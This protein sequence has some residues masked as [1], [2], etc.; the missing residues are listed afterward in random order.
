MKRV[1]NAEE[2]R[3]V[4]WAAGR[5]CRYRRRLA[6]KLY[7]CLRANTVQSQ[8]S[9][10]A[11]GDEFLSVLPPGR[12]CLIELRRSSGSYRPKNSHECRREPFDA[13]RDP[14]VTDR[15]AALPNSM[16]GNCSVAAGHF[17][18]PKERSRFTRMRPTT[19]KP[20]A[21]ICRGQTRL[22][23][24]SGLADG[25][26]KFRAGRWTVVG[27]PCRWP[28]CAEQRMVRVGPLCPEAV[29]VSIV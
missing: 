21:K 11:C 15:S 16:F 6:S 27:L 8:K 19:M 20:L 28:D 3:S 7:R 13:A 10:S 22:R 17:G 25:T 4:S 1:S 29:R 2:P 26:G 23:L 9:V 5:F 24:M 14:Q 12:S 18:K